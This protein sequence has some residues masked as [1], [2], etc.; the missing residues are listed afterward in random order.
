[1]CPRINVIEFSSTYNVGC[2]LLSALI[3]SEK[4]SEGYIFMQ[5]EHGM[6]KIHI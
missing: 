6:A 1:M 2:D 5:G 3:K 4:T